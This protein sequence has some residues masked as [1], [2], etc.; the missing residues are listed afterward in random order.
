MLTP[1]IEV[2]YMTPAQ[3]LRNEA[4][5]DKTVV[6]S[7]L[8]SKTSRKLLDG[9]NVDSGKNDFIEVYM[10]YMDNYHYLI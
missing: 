4:T 6:K 5:Y 3:L 2:L 1:Q 8:E 10:K 7:L 9:S